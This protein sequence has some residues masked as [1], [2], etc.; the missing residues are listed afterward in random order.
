MEAVVDLIDKVMNEYTNDIVI[1]Q[2]E[3]E[4][5]EMMRKRPLFIFKLKKL[6]SLI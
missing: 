6:L 2:V 3:S 4:V 1:E 5:R